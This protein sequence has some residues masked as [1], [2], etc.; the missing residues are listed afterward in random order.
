VLVK[1]NHAVED[2]T[3]L[4]EDV[5]VYLHLQLREAEFEVDPLQVRCFCVLVSFITFFVIVS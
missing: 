5:A 3:S 1:N 4:F 2:S